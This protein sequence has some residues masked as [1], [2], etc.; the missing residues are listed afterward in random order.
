MPL[1]STLCWRKVS[2]KPFFHSCLNF[3]TIVV[4]H[5]DDFLLVKFINCT[6]NLVLILFQLW[7]FNADTAV[8]TNIEPCAD[9]HGE[10]RPS[11]GGAYS[12]TNKGRNCWLNLY[13]YRSAVKFIESKTLSQLVQYLYCLDRI[14]KT[15]YLHYKKFAPLKRVHFC[16]SLVRLCLFLLFTV[17]PGVFRSLFQFCISLL[18]IADC[19]NILYFCVYSLVVI[20]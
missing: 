19:C 5:V 6:K 8:V 2:S 13:M 4:Y 20:G 10:K 3:A 12:I 15:N 16:K 18:W 17:P 9:F 11:E 1:L 7:L 14:K